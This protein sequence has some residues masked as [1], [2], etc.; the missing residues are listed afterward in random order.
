[1]ASRTFGRGRDNATAGRSPLITRKKASPSSSHD[2]SFRDTSSIYDSDTEN[3]SPNSSLDDLNVTKFSDDDSPGRYHL[4]RRELHR[5]VEVT[6]PKHKGSESDSFSYLDDSRSGASLY[7]SPVYSPYTSKPSPGGDKSP[8]KPDKRKSPR[9]IRKP[10]STYSTSS[11]T[12]GPQQQNNYGLLKNICIVC[13]SIIIVLLAVFLFHSLLMVR[14]ETSNATTQTPLVDRDVIKERF[15]SSV[16]EL[17]EKFPHQTSRFWSTVSAATKR[18]IK[19]EH[20]IQPAVLLISA[21]DGA[22]RLGD[23]IV[24]YIADII[25]D[26]HEALP[27][28]TLNISDS[29]ISL[30]AAD[31]KVK[32]E[33]HLTRN[34]GKGSKVVVVHGLHDLQPLAA[35]L[36]HAFCDNENAPYKDVV[37]AFTLHVKHPGSVRERDVERF[38][39]KIWG[40]DLDTDNLSALLSRVANNIAI[41]QH[42]SNEVL[43]NHC[44]E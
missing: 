21:P 25:T 40:S 28:T 4:R 39:H 27:S 14:Q 10:T 20:P 6:P 5:K 33:Q 34:L 43:Q 30:S 26:V 3:K 38:L 8:A 16:L 1:M 44:T 2:S 18:I 23:C 15:M 22:Y 32:L 19:D 12:R 29:L 13:V 41:V 24:R 31:A 37:L 36:L 7:S 35:M 9:L 17:K 11:P 42:E